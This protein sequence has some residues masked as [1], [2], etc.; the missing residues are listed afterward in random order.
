MILCIMD[1]IKY[2][3]ESIFCYA[4][5]SES[6][7][8]KSR[9]KIFVFSAIYVTAL[10]L[11]RCFITYNPT[12]K[13]ISFLTILSYFWLENQIEHR[14]FNKKS[15]IKN[16]NY[17]LTF[18]VFISLM[19]ECCYFTSSVVNRFSWQWLGVYDLSEKSM[20]LDTVYRSIILI[21]FSFFTL[22]VYKIRFIKIRDIKN[23][24]SHKEVFIFFGL[25]LLTVIYIK[26][27]YLQLGVSFYGSTLAWIFLFL[28]PTCLG[29]YII[30]KKFAEII[31]KLQNYIAKDQIF[32]WIVHPPSNTNF[33]VNVGGD[34]LSFLDKYEYVTS[35]FIQR[36]HAL[37]INSGCKGYSSLVFCL[38]VTSMLRGTKDWNFRKNVF[39]M[40]EELLGLN[41]GKVCKDIENIL[42]K[43]WLLNDFETL[44]SEYYNFC[45]LRNYREDSAPPSV[46]EFLINM[47]KKNRVSLKEIES[48]RCSSNPTTRSGELVS[49]N[50]E[51]IL[52][53]GSS[54]IG[55]SEATLELLKR[56]HCLIADDLVEFRRINNSIYGNACQKSRNFMESRGIGIVNVKRLIGSGA[57][58]E[59]ERVDL[60]VNLISHKECKTENETYDPIGE[61]QHWAEVLGARVPYINIPVRSGR[62]LA[63][64]IE[65]AAMN[66]RQR[67]L[68]FVASTELF[69]SLGIE[70]DNGVDSE[71]IDE[72]CIWGL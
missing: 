69:A 11:Y 30:F 64:I 26:Y 72:K 12:I 3:I 67:F 34:T 10:T 22:L 62:N 19:M 43:T 1:I 13:L 9:K 39:G 24:S 36:L 47:V 27:H 18:T 40:A 14:R 52:I 23:L 70:G 58:K 17:I 57:V 2:L 35:G 28:L 46:E 53:T 20:L 32:Q 48:N 37:G 5:C 44:E 59:V 16:W 60:I 61:V 6:I 38:F 65:T 7:G 42:K 56:G 29:S 51:G 31:N 21:L 68:G 55:K 71:V 54:G 41:Q 8:I 50:G 25:C 4:V 15:N 49:I 66:N 45:F 33:I 63:N